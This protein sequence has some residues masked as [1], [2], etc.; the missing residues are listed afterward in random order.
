MR[1][2]KVVYLTGAPASGKS[3]LCE[4][5]ARGRSDIKVFSYSKELRAHIASKRRS[6]QVTENKIRRESATLVTRRDVQIVDRR[7]T[8]LLRKLRGR[9]HVIIDS[10]AV[11]K[12][13]FGYRVTSFTR[14][15][16][17]EV[18]PNFIVVLVASA[19]Q[20]RQ[21]IRAA[22]M[23]RPFPSEFEADFHTHL[24]ASVAF[25]YAF[26]L[27]CPIYYLD[28]SKSEKCLVTT[29]AAIIDK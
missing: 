21:R 12:E 5:L 9:E 2:S 22:A 8:E 6:G 19:T 4:N 15:R 18:A 26:E 16:L 11:T 29:V 10:H 17:R 25:T 27:G 23:G 14:A 13:A 20:S 3:T 7:L 24:Q 1:G 28:A